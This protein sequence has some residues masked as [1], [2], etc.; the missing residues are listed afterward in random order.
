METEKDWEDAQQTVDSSGE[1]RKSFT[2][3]LYISM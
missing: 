1:V 2:F 3:A